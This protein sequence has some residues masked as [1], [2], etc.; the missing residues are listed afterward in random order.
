MTAFRPVILYR[1]GMGDED[2]V[3][4]AAAKKHFVVEH[5]RTD[6]CSNDLVICRYSALPFY[7]ELEQDVL[8]R[9]GELINTYEEHRYVADLQNWYEDLRGMTPE[10]WND[11]SRVPDDAFPLVIKGETNSRKNHWDTQMFARNRQDAV[12]IMLELMD[13]SL[14]G[15]QKIYFRR[16]TRLINYFTGIGGV[17]ISHEFRVFVAYGKIV[18]QGYYWQN[19][20][21]DFGTSIPKLD[22]PPEFLQEAIQKVSPN[23]NFF[24]M[25]V[26][27]TEEGN[28][29]VV[30]LNDGQQ[31]GLSMIDPEILY[32]NLYKIAEDEVNAKFIRHDSSSGD[33]GMG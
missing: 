31:S 17:P 21:D 13:D 24:V 5:Q 2:T 18:A 23:I 15:Q 28:W 30:E 32:A 1:K 33:S 3:E 16:Y 27:K 25:D 8:N 22:C 6:I 14:I 26:A 9:G 10:T 20:A 19:Y 4:I 29:I 12:R 11:L 7:R